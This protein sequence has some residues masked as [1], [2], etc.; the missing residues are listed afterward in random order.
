MELGE[1]D[2]EAKEE[3]GQFLGSVFHN[4]GVPFLRQGTLGEEKVWSVVSV[5]V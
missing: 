2:W 4:W 3:P 5:G 1:L